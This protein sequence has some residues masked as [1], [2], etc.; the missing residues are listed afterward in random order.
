MTGPFSTSPLG[1]GLATVMRLPGRTDQ[2]R[3]LDAAYSSGFR[4]F[5]VAPSYGLGRAEELLGR[6]LAS[7]SV[8]VTV[9]TKVGLPP[10]RVAKRLARIQGPLRRGLTASPRLRQWVK[11][12]SA[13]ATAAPAAPSVGQ[14]EDSLAA[15][16]REIGR[17]PDVL[18]LHEVPTDALGDAEVSALRRLREEGLVSH[19]GASG[20]SEVAE[21]GA[22]R[23]AT[24]SVVVQMPVDLRLD[25][26]IDDG[27]KA[28]VVRRLRYGLLSRHL[29]PL[30]ECLQSA[31]LVRSVESLAGLPLRTRT[32]VANLL[33]L[34]AVNRWPG[35]TLLVGSTNEANLRKLG[36]AVHADERWPTDTLAEICRELQP[37]FRP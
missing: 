29:E 23:L 18:L 1:L 19:I 32:D 27:T 4:H 12:R 7:R 9:A 37:Y 36:A 10:S 6:W 31:E 8:D 21:L 30:V 15:S 13:L 35:D 5:D 2:L 3:V 28:P 11:A 16:V 26:A 33:V 14:I 17:S 34:V 25:G 20:P 22:M 24:D